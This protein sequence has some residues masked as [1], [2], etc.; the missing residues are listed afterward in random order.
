MSL[1]K[2]APVTPLFFANHLENCKKQVKFPLGPYPVFLHHKT[3]IQ[4]CVGEAGYIKKGTKLPFYLVFKF[5]YFLKLFWQVSGDDVCLHRFLS[6][7][8]FKLIK[9]SAWYI[10]NLNQF[11]LEKYLAELF[12]YLWLG[13]QKG[14]LLSW[15]EGNPGDRKIQ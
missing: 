6:S 7:Q 13:F 4:P 1:I 3:L 12:I 14:I 8:I 11:S 2:V 9:F 5:E 10:L 15:R